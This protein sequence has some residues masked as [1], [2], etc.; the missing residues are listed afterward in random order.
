[1]TSGVHAKT[2]GLGIDLGK[3]TDLVERSTGYVMKIAG[4]LRGAAADFA[5]KKGR[6]MRCWPAWGTGQLPWLM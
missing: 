6:K 2:V 4:G 1:M 5:A 3:N